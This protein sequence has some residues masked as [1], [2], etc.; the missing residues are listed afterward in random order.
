[1][2]EPPPARSA[3]NAGAGTSPRRVVFVLYPGMAPLDLAGMRLDYAWHDLLAVTGEQ[4]QAPFTFS[5]P[6]TFEQLRK[7]D[8][9]CVTGTDNPFAVLNDNALLD[10]LAAVGPS[11]HWV[12]SV[13][14]GSILLAAAG[15][16]DG[17]RA[18]GHWAMLEE[19]GLFGAA[20]SDERVVIDRNRMSGAGVTSGID[21]S[22]ALIELLFGRP[23]AQQV[24]LQMQYDPQPPLAAGTPVQAGAR[25]SAKAWEQVFARVR[26]GTPDYQARLM[27]AQRR[28]RD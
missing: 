15:L 21:F 26:L 3:C 22:L 17:Y 13:G 23:L 11:A 2:T 1:M 12:T 28:L 18:A 10:W 27:A 6:V 14:S 4:A 9:L 7:V 8:I 25:V 24:Q 5:P 19:L 16:L 20:P